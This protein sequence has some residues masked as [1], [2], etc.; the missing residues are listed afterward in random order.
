MTGWVALVMCLAL[1]A[2][3]GPIF[4]DNFAK[5]TVADSDSVS[6]FWV[7]TLNGADGFAVESGGTLTLTAEANSTDS[8]LAKVEHALDS[9]FNFLNPT[10][11]TFSANIG[12]GGNVE[13]DSIADDSGAH[14][15]ESAS[16]GA[17]TAIAI[18]TGRDSGKGNVNPLTTA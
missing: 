13:D 6:G 7:P 11:M 3:A 18:N 5:G 10:G 17:R 1:N 15:I 8:T 9:Q 2:S 16:W 14:N 4:V 12:T